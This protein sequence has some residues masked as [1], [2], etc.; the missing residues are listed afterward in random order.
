MK[1]KKVSW[2]Q[3]CGE[4][5]VDEN[6]EMKKFEVSYNARNVAIKEAYFGNKVIIKNPNPGA[7]ENAASLARNEELE[8]RNQ[9]LYQFYHCLQSRIYSKF[10]TII[11]RS[12]IEC[13]QTKSLTRTRF[14]QNV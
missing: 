2:A 13:N 3:N 7:K 10:Y 11:L 6:C 12:E 4:E 14:Q 8:Q 1:S 9:V 5:A